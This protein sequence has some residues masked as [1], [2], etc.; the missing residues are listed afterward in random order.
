MTQFWRASFSWMWDAS[1]HYKHDIRP[2]DVVVVTTMTSLNLYIKTDRLARSLTMKTHWR[3][4]RT[5]FFPSSFSILTMTGRKNWIEKKNNLKICL[6]AKCFQKIFFRMCLSI[7]SVLHL[8]KLNWLGKAWIKIYIDAVDNEKGRK[9]GQKPEMAGIEIL[10]VPFPTAKWWGKRLDF[11]L[12]LHS[13]WNSFFVSFVFHPTLSVMHGSD[14]S[15]ISKNVLI[16]RHYKYR[17]ELTL[18]AL[19]M[20]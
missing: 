3:I 7:H 11:L 2:T 4:F 14:A 10:F 20:M 15:S 8:P 16:C 17:P 1:M 13:F 18:V 19:V 12:S 5:H 9:P 6:P